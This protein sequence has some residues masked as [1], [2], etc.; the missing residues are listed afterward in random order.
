[1]S[2]LRSGRFILLTVEQ[3]LARKRAGLHVEW[4]EGV[5]YHYFPDDDPPPGSE[6]E[7]RKMR[8]KSV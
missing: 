6:H 3:A 7:N 8:L 5:L 4:D 1:M 2:A